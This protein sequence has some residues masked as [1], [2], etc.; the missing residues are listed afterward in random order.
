[1]GSLNRGQGILHT[2]GKD[3]TTVVPVGKDVAKIS[4]NKI[5]LFDF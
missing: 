2:N 3:R 4:T 5:E 1:M